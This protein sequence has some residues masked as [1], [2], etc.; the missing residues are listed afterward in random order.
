MTTGLAT[1]PVGKPVKKNQHVRLKTGGTVAQGLPEL[2]QPATFSGEC[3]E[4]N[5]QY[6]Q[7]C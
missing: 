2:R 5:G 1:R 4:N 3:S 7:Q 6:Y